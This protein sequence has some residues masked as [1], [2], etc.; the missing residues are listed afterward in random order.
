M[1]YLYS[2]RFLFLFTILLTGCG[3][4]TFDASTDLGKR[5]LLDEAFGLLAADSSRITSR[6]WPWGQTMHGVRRRV[7]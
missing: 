2:R 7:T 5:A 1:F 6:K 4:S 3:A